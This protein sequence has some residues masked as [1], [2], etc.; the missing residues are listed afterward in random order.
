MLPILG[1]LP[2]K[3]GS[4]QRNCRGE[5]IASQNAGSVAALDAKYEFRGICQ[6]VIA[7]GDRSI[8]LHLFRQPLT[9]VRTNRRDGLPQMGQRKGDTVLVW[10][11]ASTGPR[12]IH[13]GSS[14]NSPL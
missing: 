9:M 11:V 2:E 13:T 6:K 14:L 10:A 12:T 3:G 7:D 4:L 5:C 8:V 1:Q